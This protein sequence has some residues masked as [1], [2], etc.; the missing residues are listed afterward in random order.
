MCPAKEGHFAGY[1]EMVLKKLREAILG[2]NG[3]DQGQ[4]LLL[5]EESSEGAALRQLERVLII[6]D[7]QAQ[8]YVCRVILERSGRVRDVVVKTD[9]DSAYQYLCEEGGGTPTLVLL[10]IGMPIKDGWQ[11]LDDFVQLPDEQRSNYKVVI[12]TEPALGEDEP[13]TV[14][15]EVPNVSGFIPKPLEDDHVEGLIEEHF[16][17][18]Q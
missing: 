15:T 14:P 6:D 12:L 5:R 18:A 7:N 11:F 1:G 16:P 8:N 17:L 13:L 4:D 2:D 3:V 9:A 10:D